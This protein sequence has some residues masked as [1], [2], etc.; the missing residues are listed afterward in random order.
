[1]PI[2]KFYLKFPSH[3]YDLIQTTE[4]INYILMHMLS[5]ADESDYQSKSMQFTIFCFQALNA[6]MKLSGETQWQCIWLA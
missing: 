3:D 4:Y 1:M 5:S 2:H 6:H